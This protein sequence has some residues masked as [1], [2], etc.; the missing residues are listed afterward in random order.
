MLIP[1]A[2]RQGRVWKFAV[3]PRIK[4]SPSLSVPRRADHGPGSSQAPPQQQ[5]AEPQGLSQSRSPA[6]RA[7]G[8]G[9]LQQAAAR[10][11]SPSLET[12]HKGEKAL[13]P[14][15]RSPFPPAVPG[16]PAQRCPSCERVP[17]IPGCGPSL[18]QTHCVRTAE[19]SKRRRGGAAE[20]GS[21]RALAHPDSRGL[22]TSLSGTFPRL[23]NNICNSFT[24]FISATTKACYQ[25]PSLVF[26]KMIQL[27]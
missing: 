6:P 15:P 4:R 27:H 18:R 24:S 10:V 21:I 11:Q 25:T 17:H 7:G 22:G 20:Q 16:M 1:L 14:F 5:Q 3:F 9:C 23:Q 19:G 2:A 13:S 12:R 8:W 26:S